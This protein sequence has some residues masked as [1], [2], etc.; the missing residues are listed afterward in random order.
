[1]RFAG[2]RVDECES[3]RDLRQQLI[4]S[5][6]V[7]AVIMVEDI[8]S[9]PPEA[10]IAAKSYFDGPLV[11]FESRYPTENEHVFDLR[12]HN[13]TEPSEWLQRIQTVISNY[14]RARSTKLRN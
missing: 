1:M 5:T 10:I 4:A 3:I 14:T 13:L 11:L 2:F 7:D 9:I 12:V 6:D 8:V